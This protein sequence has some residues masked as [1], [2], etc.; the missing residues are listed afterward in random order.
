MKWRIVCLLFAIAWGVLLK[1]SVVWAQQLGYSIEGNRVV[2][3]SEEHW[4]RWKAAAKSIQVTDEGVRPGFI[5]KSTEI[6]IDGRI[7][8][9]PGINASLNAS[10]FGGDNLD[11]AAGS[12]PSKVSDLLDGR[13]DTFW[14]PDRDDRI[15]DW[16]VQIDLGRAVSATKVVLKF[17][18]DDLGDPFLLFKVLTSQGLVDNRILRYRQVFVTEKKLKDER[19]V[20]VELTLTSKHI[21]GGPRSPAASA[22]KIEEFSGDAIRYVQVA[23]AGSDFGKA[24]QVSKA[25]FESLESNRRGDVEY[26]RKAASGRLRLL[27]GKELWEALDESKRGPVVH[28]RR[29]LPRLAELEVWS[30]GDNVALGVIDRGGALSSLEN[31][32]EERI[33]NGDLTDVWLGKQG[34]SIESIPPNEPLDV[35]RD[36]FIDLGGAF[37]LDNARVIMSITQPPSGF[38]AYFLK[39]SDGSRGA[40]GSVLFKTVASKSGIGSEDAFHNHNFE[41]TKVRFFKFTTAFIAQ[42][43]AVTT[44]GG[45]PAGLAE[46]QLFG[47]GFVAET[48]I[49]SVFEEG[50]PFI[51]LGTSKNLVSIEWDADTPPGTDVFIQTKTGDTSETEYRYFDIGKKKEFTTNRRGESPKEQ[52]EKKVDLFWKKRDP[53]TPTLK[54]VCSKGEDVIDQ[55]LCRKWLVDK[56]TNFEVGPIVA[57]ILPGSDW[58]GWS[59][60]YEHPGDKITSPS[61]RR[62]VTIRATLL[63]DDPFQSATLRS[64]TLNFLN[65]VAANVVG[66]IKPT[67]LDELGVNQEF[68][69]FIRPT[70]DSDDQEFDEI[71]IEAPPG[72]RMNFKQV[73]KWEDESIEDMIINGLLREPDESYTE[74]SEGFDVLPKDKPDPSDSLWVHL[75]DVIKTTTRNVLLEVK[76]EAQLFGFSTFFDGFIGSSS[77]PRSWQRVDDGDANG[78]TDSERT[79]VLALE[80]NKILD[81]IVVDPEII[82]PNGDG[83]NDETSISFSVLRVGSPTTVQVQIYD[84]SGNIVR[85]LLND[86]LPSGRYTV[87]WAGV[88]KSGDLVPLGIYII[89]IN[90]DSDSGSVEDT[91]V[92]RLVHVAY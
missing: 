41:L 83:I 4:S 26:F 86:S 1:D 57:D 66:E 13:M 44:G 42:L 39:V 58:S 27:S 14:E 47:E 6:E 63:T 85:E 84:L 51:E 32:N 54:D 55:K 67:R 35:E 11:L 71:L 78:V 68:S 59:Q 65:P 40:D 7:V 89:R 90:V 50:A 18:G 79:I 46:I 49:E 9:V 62:F 3:D 34:F 74:E 36:L 75:P 56:N 48:Q 92:I 8:R 80:G 16:W 22:E 73:N 33:V 29:E 31:R 60:R 81:N 12:N 69:Y 20:E 23:I 82:T 43:A 10:E 15:E 17:V 30:I 61:P 28:Y 72:V 91:S 37:F 38:G 21:R 25:T 45:T 53:I 52:Y 5:H 77:V 2:I 76:F 88:D 64:L 87:T 24:R 70:F 19:V